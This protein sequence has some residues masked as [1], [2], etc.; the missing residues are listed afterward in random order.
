M[1]KQ[2]GL[3]D[4]Y[5]VD[6]YDLSGDTR[7]LGRV[8]GG[9]AALDL[10]GIDRSA[11]E[12]VGG[13]RTGTIQWVSYFN[14]TA[15]QAHPV[16]SARP[17]TDRIATYCRGTG[18]GSPAASCVAK[19]IGYDPSRADDGMLTIGVSVD[20]N[21]Y[22][23]EWGQLL[24][25][26][27]RTDTAATNGSSVDGAAATTEGGQA[28]LH[29]FSFT[30]TDVTIG[31]EDSANNSAFTAVTGL[32]FTAVTAAPFTQR[33]AT[34]AGATVRRYLRAATTTSAG[35]TSVVYAVVV[36]RNETAVTF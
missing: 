33:L 36:V 12:R 31:V 3:G 27:K 14:D 29:V 7:S 4:N 30:G 35:F 25:A 17:T 16:L 24:T 8:S 32:T 34:A 18:L 21:R 15:G 26:G 20:S 5:Y 19:Q 10:T 11:Y 22:G 6:G 2:S 28:Y 1:A 13:I 9:P 23:L